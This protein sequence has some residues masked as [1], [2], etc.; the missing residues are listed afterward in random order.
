MI[1]THT[2]W[3]KQKKERE[4]QDE[5]VIE[6]TEIVKNT[7]GKEGKR[8]DIDGLKRESLDKMKEKINEKGEELRWLRKKRL[9]KE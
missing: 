9:L 4:K 3:N 6:I 5:K 8:S 1:V 2:Q 7:R